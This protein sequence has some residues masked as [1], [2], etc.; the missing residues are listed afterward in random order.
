LTKDNERLE[1][2][3]KEIEEIRIERLNLWHQEDVIHKRL[4]EL[5]KRN[6]ELTTE[7]LKIK[8]PWTLQKHC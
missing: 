6:S 1:A 3:A 7:Y 8:C 4:V 5:G 2:L